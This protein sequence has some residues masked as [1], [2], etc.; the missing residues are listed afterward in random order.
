M[1]SPKISV[2]IPSFNKA[3]FINETLRS[4]F[5]QNYQNF[6]VI[7]Q[8][9]ESTDGTLK[10]IKKYARKYPKKIEWESRKDKGQLD[11]VLKGIRKAKGDILTFINADDYYERGAFD[12]MSSAFIKHPKALWFAGRGKVIDADGY[13]ITKPVTFYKDLLLFL[14]WYPLL[15]ITN[16][17]MQPSVFFTKKAYKKYGPFTGTGEFIMEYDLWL[18]LGRV[19]MP[20]VVNKNISR[21]RIEPF[22][23]TKRLFRSLLLEDR[24]IVSRFTTNPLILSLHKIHNYGRIMIGRFV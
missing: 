7:I 8:D 4:I 11:A 15:L 17:L 21:F 24:K 19:E 10:V 2:I 22:T 14:S 16:Y 20:Q 9:G 6:E 1:D 23:K 3:E 13:E 5:F 12:A 18:K